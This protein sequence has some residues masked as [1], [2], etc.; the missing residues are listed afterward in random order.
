MDPVTTL[1]LV[2][3]LLQIISTIELVLQ[4]IEDVNDASSDRAKLTQEALSLL[5]L[6]QYLKHRLE[7]TNSTDPWFAGIC[8]LGMPKGPLEQMKAAIEELATLLQPES[9][10]KKFGKKL[11][12]T[13]DNKKCLEL[14]NKIERLKT[15]IALA[16]QGDLL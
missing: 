5:S 7:N 3:S 1:G 6:L 9:G 13:R 16:V 12:W 8:W 11:L 4:Y 10:I 15:D 14:L 2:A